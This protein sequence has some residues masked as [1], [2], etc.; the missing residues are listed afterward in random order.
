MKIRLKLASLVLLLFV[1]TN[2]IKENEC[3]CS[4]DYTVLGLK[5]RY[6]TNKSIH[7]QTEFPPNAMLAVFI[8][9]DKGTFVSQINDSLGTFIKYYKISQLIHTQ[10]IAN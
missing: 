4:Q 6:A 7:Q 2:C 3:C 9:D 8:F 1:L 5:F 10:S